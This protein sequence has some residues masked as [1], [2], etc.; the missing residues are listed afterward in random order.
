MCGRGHVELIAH[1]GLQAHSST[2]CAD[3]KCKRRGCDDRRLS[4]RLNLAELASYRRNLQPTWRKRWRGILRATERRDVLYALLDASGL[5]PLQSRAAR[6]SDAHRSDSQGCTGGRFFS[7]FCAHASGGCRL[8]EPRAP[9][10]LAPPLGSVLGSRPVMSLLARSDR[11]ERQQLFPQERV[12][13]AWQP[14]LVLL[15]EL[16]LAT[17]PSPPNLVLRDATGEIPLLLP[18]EEMAAATL[19]LGSI[20][21]ITAFEFLARPQPSPPQDPESPATG[22]D[23]PVPRATLFVRCPSGIM[24]KYSATQQLCDVAAMLLLPNASTRAIPPAADERSLR[25][26]QWGAPS[27]PPDDPPVLLRP[28]LIPLGSASLDASF[29]FRALVCMVPERVVDGSGVPR[30]QGRS[31]EEMALALR[32]PLQAWAPLLQLGCEYAIHGSL[33]LIPRDGGSALELSSPSVYIELTRRVG[34]S[35]HPAR[36]PRGSSLFELYTQLH[37][38]HRRATRRVDVSCVLREARFREGATVELALTSGDASQRIQAFAD[39][40]QVR[41]PAGLLAGT[42]LL[43]HNVEAKHSRGGMGKLYLKVDASSGIVLWQLP[44]NKQPQPYAEPQWD[45]RRCDTLERLSLHP[46]VRPAVRLQITVLRLRELTFKWRCHAC[47]QDRAGT[48]CDCTSLDSVLPS[49]TGASFEEGALAD[50]TDGSGKAMLEVPGRLVWAL[51]QASDC[52]ASRV[53]AIARE[54]G[55]LTLTLDRQASHCLTLGGG[56]W[57]CSPHH[58]IVP[59]EKRALDAAIPSALHWQRAF[60]ALCKRTSLVNSDKAFQLETRRET[61]VGGQ[62]FNLRVVHGCPRLQALHLQVRSTRNELERAFSA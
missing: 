3:G 36:V 53:A 28:T 27:L 61:R 15:G 16:A 39:P 40:G 62:P 17:P 9:M 59:S 58:T 60:D 48:S 29:T 33:H 37:M 56:V 30:W 11:L 50:V 49:A 7:Q 1:A 34:G 35:D 52:I 25:P 2:G 8:G 18:P 10:P 42:H 20:Y 13:A 23:I 31:F 14:Q 21:A 19:R 46:V 43:L 54:V 57:K 5:K 22:T 6:S 51:L 55:P 44:G 47:G 45:G 38:C 26:L 32:P 4:L 12:A 41:L 24:G